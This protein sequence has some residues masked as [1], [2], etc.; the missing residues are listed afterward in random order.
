MC[1]SVLEKWRWFKLNQWK[2]KRFIIDFLGITLFLLS[3]HCNLWLCYFTLWSLCCQVKVPLETSTDRRRNQSECILFGTIPQRCGN[4]VLSR[5]VKYNDVILSDICLTQ[6]ESFRCFVLH[7]F[8]LFIIIWEFSF[9]FCLYHFHDL[10][11]LLWD[12][13]NL[14]QVN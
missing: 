5:E 11:C 12:L 14:W 8:C 2:E 3:L 6:C 7:V 9:H 4:V 1:L 10:W 13:N